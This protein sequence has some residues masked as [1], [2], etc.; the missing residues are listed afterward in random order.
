MAKLLV[1]TA[2]MTKAMYSIIIILNKGALFT[3]VHKMVAA[4]CHAAMTNCK[5]EK[6]QKINKEFLNK[7]CTSKICNCH[8]KCRYKN[9][10]VR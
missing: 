4:S 5:A 2:Q 8:S 9:I 1:E 6:R 10:D 3:S 7:I